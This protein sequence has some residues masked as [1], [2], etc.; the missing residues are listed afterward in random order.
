[1][2]YQ[3]Y[4]KLSADEIEKNYREGVQGMEGSY[5][6]LRNEEDVERAAKYS[7]NRFAKANLESEVLALARARVDLAPDT[8]YIPEEGMCIEYESKSKGNIDSYKIVRVIHTVGDPDDV[9]WMELSHRN[10][11]D[12]S[13]LAEG[14]SLIGEMVYEEWAK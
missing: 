7:G 4:R 5:L 3:I 6:F 1:M 2:S 12:N 14:D 10:F 8:S 11:L 9:L 13:F